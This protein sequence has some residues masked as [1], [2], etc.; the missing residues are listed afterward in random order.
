[1]KKVFLKPGLHR[2]RNY[3]RQV[4]PSPPPWPPPDRL[5]GL[6]DGAAVAEI[7]ARVRGKQSHHSPDETEL[8]QSL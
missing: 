8:A 7:T 1:M 6:K 4:S 2:R 5:E 3:C